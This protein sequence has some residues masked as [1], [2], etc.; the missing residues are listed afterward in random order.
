[1]HLRSPKP[2]LLPS[3]YTVSKCLFEHLR[4]FLQLT[5]AQKA[6][7]W[8]IPRLVQGVP[9]AGTPPRPSLQSGV[10]CTSELQE[11]QG[12]FPW[13][14]DHRIPS[15][16]EITG[17]IFSKKRFEKCMASVRLFCRWLG[18]GSS[19]RHYVT[20]IV[21]VA[22]FST[23]FQTQISQHWASKSQLPR[24]FPTPLPRHTFLE[25]RCKDWSEPHCDHPKKTK[26]QVDCTKSQSH[27][28]S[29]CTARLLSSS[30][31]PQ[32]F[33][34]WQQQECR[35]PCRSDCGLVFEER[36]WKITDMIWHD[37]KILKL[38]NMSNSRQQ[39]WPC[40]HACRLW[41]CRSVLT[42]HYT[43]HEHLQCSGWPF[44][45][46][47]CIAAKGWRYT[48][49]K[50]ENM[51]NN[52]KIYEIWFSFTR[53]PYN[54]P[55][56]I[57]EAA[58]LD[59]MTRHHLWCWKGLSW[60]IRYPVVDPNSHDVLCLVLCRTLNMGWYVWST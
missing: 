35:T 38:L 33:P 39:L 17:D 2:I 59:L 28:V 3:L 26:N 58:K 45:T 25:T 55:S 34:R 27:S 48:L 46:L 29:C 8:Q 47:H 24:P 23:G 52:M 1:M 7:T 40:K 50:F 53:T 4:S 41:I 37:Y 9:C 13:H 18:Q 31:V 51:T 16:M 30:M 19:L 42:C 14:H 12:G 57:H 36:K 11:L 44:A 21:C 49:E 15:T 56:L 32:A 6:K 22:L 54:G 60:D 5:Q 10:H 20:N 43:M